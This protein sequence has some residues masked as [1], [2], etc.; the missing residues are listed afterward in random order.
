MAVEVLLRR[1]NDVCIAYG[2]NMDRSAMKRRRTMRRKRR[3]ASFR[4]NPDVRY[5]HKADITLTA[6]D[7]AFGGKAEMVSHRKM[8]ANDPKRTLS[9]GHHERSGFYRS[10]RR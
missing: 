3:V 7:S 4:K 9:A 5:W 6:I 2:A 10:H 1:C 8:S